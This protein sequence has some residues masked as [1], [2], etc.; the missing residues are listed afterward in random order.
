MIINYQRLHVSMYRKIINYFM[1]ALCRIL[2]IKTLRLH[3]GVV[4]N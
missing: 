1:H 2:K 4:G 3:L